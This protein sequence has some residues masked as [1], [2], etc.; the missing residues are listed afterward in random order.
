MIPLMIVAAL[1]LIAFGWW[2][3]S[4]HY[5]PKIAYLNHMLALAKTDFDTSERLRSEAADD[6]RRLRNQLTAQQLAMGLAGQEFALVPKKVTPAHYVV[7][8]VKR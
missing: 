7:K 4:A 5:S 2:L 1:G 8:A 6:N 3:G